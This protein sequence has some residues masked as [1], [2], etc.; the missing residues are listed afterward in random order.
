MKSVVKV[1]DSFVGKLR[2]V[3]SRDWFLSNDEA[4]TNFASLEGDSQ[5]EV[6]MRS[7]RWITALALC[8][9]VVGMSGCSSLAGGSSSTGKW[10]DFGN[11]VLNLDQ[12]SRIIPESSA[13]GTIYIKFD[14]FILT[15][16]SPDIKGKSDE[17]AVAAQRSVLDANMKQ[18]RDFLNS[19]KSYMR[20]E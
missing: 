7:N 10:L 5:Q 1:I 11:G 6:S 8:A 2:S 16:Q 15:L 20:L 18:V 13:L 12:T 19:N 14:E 9:A 3:L 4:V 17:E